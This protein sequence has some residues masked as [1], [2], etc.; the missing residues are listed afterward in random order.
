M[1]RTTFSA[2]ALNLA[3]TNAISQCVQELISQHFAGWPTLSYDRA[4]R[5]FVFGGAC[6]TPVNLFADRL[7]DR[8][9]DACAPS[10]DARPYLRVALG[11]SVPTNSVLFSGAGPLLA[12]RT[13][14]D[15]RAAVRANLIRTAALSAAIMVP[16]Q[17]YARKLPKR[18]AALLMQLA[19]T[20]LG[21][22]IKLDMKKRL[23]AAAAARAAAEAAETRRS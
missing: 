3:L 13:L 23:Q 14:A 15:A 2:D 9:T 17:L 11:A 21:L 6:F 20:L 10:P 1:A 5:Y 16:L 22:Y 19:A 12:G 4:L 18:R 7:M 8:L